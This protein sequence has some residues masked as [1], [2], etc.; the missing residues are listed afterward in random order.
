MYYYYYKSKIHLTVDQPSNYLNIEFL[1][2]ISRKELLK[3][4]LSLSKLFLTAT[5]ENYIKKVQFTD[6]R[7]SKYGLWSFQMGGTKLERFLPK[8]QHTQRQLLNFENWVNGEVS[9]VPKFD[10][11]SQF[12][13]SK[14]I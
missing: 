7:L 5:L 2:Q 14:I 13:K 4:C 12:S 9:K 6:S 11:Q 3:S 8:N 10:F 1:D